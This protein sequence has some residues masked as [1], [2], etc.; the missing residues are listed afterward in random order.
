MHERPRHP[1]GHRVQVALSTVVVTGSA[2]GIG[3]AC[4]VRLRS[5]GF[6]VVG[7]DLRDAE[8]IADLSTDEGRRSAIDAVV[9]RSGGAIAGLV[10]C[11]GLAGMPSRAGSLLTAVNYFG[12][13]EL[14]D[15]LRPLLVGDGAA[16]AISSNSTTVQPG[17]PM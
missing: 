4:A 7:I 11:A 5:D 3:A 13:V 14:L 16:V 8:I 6:E 15:G 10:T 2:S 9:A 12:T 17:V 1:A